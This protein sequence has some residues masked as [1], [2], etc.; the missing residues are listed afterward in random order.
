M[1]LFQYSVLMK[2]LNKR[3]QTDREIDRMVYKIYGL[4]EVDIG[5]V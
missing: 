4:T 1:R 3:G 2:N 5:V